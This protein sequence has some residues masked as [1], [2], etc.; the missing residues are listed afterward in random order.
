M[1]VIFP[2]GDKRQIASLCLL[3]AGNATDLDLA[4][5]FQLAFQPFS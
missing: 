4:V 3:D 1:L 2:I 5:A